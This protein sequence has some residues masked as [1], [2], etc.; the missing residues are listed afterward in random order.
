[1]PEPVSWISFGPEEGLRLR[2]PTSSTPPFHAAGL[3]KL[4]AAIED[5]L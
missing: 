3:E 1:M 5:M 2:E 4:A